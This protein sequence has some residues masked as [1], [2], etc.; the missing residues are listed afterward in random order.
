MVDAHYDSA[1][2]TGRIIL[3][4]NRSWSWRANVYFFTTLACVSLSVAM[5]LTV[6]GF[7]LVLPFSM[8]ELGLVLLALYFC[9]RRTYRQE[10]ITVSP[11]AL[12]IEKGHQHVEQTARFPRFF[13]RVLIDRAG[14]SRRVAV[15]CRGH[16]LEIGSFLSGED[17]EKLINGMRWIISLLNGAGA[18]GAD[19]TGAASAAARN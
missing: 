11:D 14:R 17:K 18:H 5:T 2:Q 4:P 9:V 13:T 6:Q 10:V 16:Q 1:A 7:W 19:P 3:R 8:L 15:R 12:I